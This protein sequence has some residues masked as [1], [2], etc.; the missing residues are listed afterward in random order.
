MLF[1]CCNPRY[2]ITCT[3]EGQHFIDRLIKSIKDFKLPYEFFNLHIGQSESLLPKIVLDK[4]PFV[5][6]FLIDGGHGWPTVFVD[7]CYAYYATKQNGF[8]ALDD[9]QLLSVSTLASFL[10]EQPGFEI[11][12]NLDKTIIFK[13]LYADRYL[14]DFGG[15]P[16]ITSQTS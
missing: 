3:L 1:L 12:L 16:Y 6:F 11:A 14:P 10:M 15:Q 4:D 8:I 5:D 9:T 2:V 13:K 7:F